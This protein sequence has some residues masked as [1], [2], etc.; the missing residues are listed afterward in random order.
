[1]A[2][3]EPEADLDFRALLS[4]WLRRP[5]WSVIAP[6][7]LIAFAGVFA[8]QIFFSQSKLNKGLA[9]LNGSYRQ[10]RPLEARLAGFGY[11]PFRD[12]GGKANEQSLKQAEEI[13]FTQIKQPDT[14]TTLHARGQFYIAMHKFDEAI[15]QFDTALKLE[16]N[17]AQILNDLGIAWMEKATQNKS[18]PDANKQ[19]AQ[20]RIH[21]E[22]ALQHDPRSLEALFNLALLDFRQGRWKAAEERWQVYLKNDER[23][24]WAGE[25]KTYLNRIKSLKEQSTNSIV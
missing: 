20:S 17:N 18:S 6:I 5:G 3:T 7:L 8:W 19:F 9:A 2:A 24:A 4:R 23:S 21:L 10:G 11:A 25:A 22:Q 13:L 14:S 15:Q 12:S 1:M 16:A